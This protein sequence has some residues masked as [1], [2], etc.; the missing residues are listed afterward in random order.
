MQMLKNA[1]KFA[2]A[3]KGIAKW[4]SWHFESSRKSFRG[5]NGTISGEVSVEIIDNF[6]N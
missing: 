2:D 4:T 3:K 5:L 6:W 1:W